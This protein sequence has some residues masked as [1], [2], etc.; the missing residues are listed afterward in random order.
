MRIT[1][2]I[3]LLTIAALSFAQGYQIEIQINS[4]Q[5]KEIKLTHYYLD[6]VFVK[7]SLTLN[8]NG[9]GTFAGF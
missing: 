6:N 9:S 5:N 8:E 2:L 4:A 1:V 7:D 3:L